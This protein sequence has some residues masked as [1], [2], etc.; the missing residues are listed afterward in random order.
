[1]FDKFEKND[2]TD[3]KYIMKVLNEKY[4]QRNNEMNN[5][6]AMLDEEGQN[7]HKELPSVYDFSNVRETRTIYDDF[8]TKKIFI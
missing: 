2:V 3:P 6:T 7:F 1:M 4:D 8:N 5:M